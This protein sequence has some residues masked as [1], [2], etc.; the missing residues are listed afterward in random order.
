MD[1]PR[2][3][4][5]STSLDTTTDTGKIFHPGQDRL[6]S[7]RQGRSL[8]ISKGYIFKGIFW[9][10]LDFFLTQNFFSYLPFEDFCH[11]EVHLRSIMVLIHG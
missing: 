5:N 2:E 9:I 10:L 3:F 11:S 7:H 6:V 4:M 1:P 8:M